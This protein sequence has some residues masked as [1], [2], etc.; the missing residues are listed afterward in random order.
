MKYVPE[1]GTEKILFMEKWKS[2]VNVII[3]LCLS[4]LKDIVI[5]HPHPHSTLNLLLGQKK[6]KKTEKR[7]MIFFVCEAHKSNLHL[8]P[9]KIT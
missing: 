6:K 5:H 3:F 7:V 8:S 2:S 1:N 4:Q 9:T